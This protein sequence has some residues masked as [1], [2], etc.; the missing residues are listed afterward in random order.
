[1]KILK[2]CIPFMAVLI[3]VSSC[4]VQVDPREK[5]SSDFLAKHI[6]S[7][8]NISVDSL[9]NPFWTKPDKGAKV[10][11]SFETKDG[12]SGYGNIDVNYDY[13][14]E[15]VDSYYHPNI[16]LNPHKEV[17]EY[18]LRDNREEEAFGFTK[19]MMIV[20]I[21]EQYNERELEMISKYLCYTD[22]YFSDHLNIS[23]YLEKMSLKGPNYA[24]VDVHSSPY[25]IST[26]VSI[27]ILTAIP[28][29]T[30]LTTETQKTID[31]CPFKNCKVLGTWQFIGAS[32]ITIYVK[33][34]AYY[35]ATYAE[36]KY[37]PSDKLI[38]IQGDGYPSFKYEEDT[39][40]YFSIHSDGLYGYA[41]GDLAC[42][43]N[44]M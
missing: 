35:M 25:N 11:F 28:Q 3:S 36:G 38:K 37:L 7:Y 43:Y 33:N 2:Y 10:N 40:E 26:N 23:Y 18:S 13:N 15:Y 9:T 19:R 14:K 34:G 12:F 22:G 32:T 6:P 30:D 1:M 17:K 31:D 20:I 41:F 4:F 5:A 29:E 39:G 8:V 24:F 21:P 42:V 16:H 44:N 27:N